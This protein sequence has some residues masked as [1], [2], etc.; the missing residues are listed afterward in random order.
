MHK[1][2]KCLHLADP[3]FADIHHIAPGEA[4]VSVGV[5]N[6]TADSQL[7]VPYFEVSEAPSESAAAQRKRLAAPL[8][9]AV[10]AVSFVAAETVSG[11]RS[12]RWPR[13]G[14]A[15]ASSSPVWSN[16]PSRPLY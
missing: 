7:V 10:A 12:R 14:W 15:G 13:S 5:G 4:G 1:P 3:S 16:A 2:V 9:A 8:F 11:H 6:S